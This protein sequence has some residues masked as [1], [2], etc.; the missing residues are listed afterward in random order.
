M[1]QGYIG[2][3]IAERLQMPP[4]LEAAWHTHGYYG[5]V[6]HNV[7]AI[8][9]RYLGWYDGNPAHLWQ[10]PPVE[11]AARYV[12][13]LGG[14][15]ATV[16]KARDYASAGDLRFAAELASHAVFATPDDTDARSALAE[17]LTD[18]AFGSEN[19]TWRNVFL[20]G[21]SELT[22]GIRPTAIS[23]SG[24]A[25]AMTVTQLFDTVAITIDGEKAWSTELSILWHVTDI[26]EHYRMELSNGA[27]NHHPTNRSDPADLV[28]TLTRAQLLA[29]LGTGNTD[30]ITL[31]GDESAF[32]TLASF[33]DRP[34]PSFA[35]VTP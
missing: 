22:S 14:T 8:F 28:I 17:I 32:A 5:S 20:V 34:D 7:K 31:D 4:G 1:N 30:G 15:E 18:L 21:A 3:E 2:S 13:L 9:Q 29:L 35:V 6:S 26:D 12:E 27:L 11:T 25:A 33:S 10:H 19:A 23:G 24:L 16:A